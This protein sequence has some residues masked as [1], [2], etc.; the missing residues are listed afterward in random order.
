[1]KN[2][3]PKAPPT[4]HLITCGTSL[5]S[6]LKRNNP[7]FNY[8]SAI[9]KLKYNHDKLSNAAYK[10][11]IAHDLFYGILIHDQEGSTL[12]TLELSKGTLYD[13]LEH[14]T[15]K[16]LN[17]ETLPPL[18]MAIQKQ[19]PSELN[20]KNTQG[21]T[22]NG[23][24]LRINSFR[25]NGLNFT[26]F[27]A[28]TFPPQVVLEEFLDLFDSFIEEYSEEITQ[29]KRLGKVSGDLRFFR[30]KTKMK[31]MKIIQEY[32]N[33]IQIY[34]T[35]YSKSLIPHALKKLK[36]DP[37]G[38]SAEL[39]SLW[40]FVGSQDLKGCTLLATDTPEGEFCAQVISQYINEEFT[41]PTEVYR[42]HEF[43][44]KNIVDGI[45]NLKN[46]VM[47]EIERIHALS[48]RPEIYFNLTGGFKPEAAMMQL[49]GGLYHIKCYYI[50]ETTRE[51]VLL[52][53]FPV[54]SG[55][56]P[57]YDFLIAFDD[58]LSLEEKEYQDFVQKNQKQFNIS[59]KMNYINER[60]GCDS[61]MEE[62]NHVLTLTPKGR[63]F[64]ETAEDFRYIRKFKSG[65]Q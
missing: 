65:L 5:L 13:N 48:S 40:E 34:R 57:L 14:L 22:L 53:S 7:L 28:Y 26:L 10:N 62:E 32:L 15:G 31:I 61:D 21:F 37:R 29:F 64:L 24:N 56:T 46:K 43:G 3:K 50:Y 20:I 1:M 60:N 55:K 54:G 8:K 49:L 27:T 16:A 36:E 11:Q 33:H 52:P 41:V 6:N 2:L 44:R 23:E 18:L 39:N 45:M 17:P 30:T 59:L 25:Y 19:V 38:Y 12:D 51:V 9:E 42:I 63:L 4:Y 58:P 47:K 35:R